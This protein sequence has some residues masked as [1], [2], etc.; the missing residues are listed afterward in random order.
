MNSIGRSPRMGY[1][2]FEMNAF[3]MSTSQIIDKVDNNFVLNRRD[4]VISNVDRYGRPNYGASSYYS[5]AIII[6]RANE[7]KHVVSIKPVSKQEGPSNNLLL[8]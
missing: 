6:V 1:E 7:I 4:N 5:G 3:D 8:L 2:V